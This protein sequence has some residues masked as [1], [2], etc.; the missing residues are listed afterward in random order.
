[1]DYRIEL[2]VRDT[3]SIPKELISEL[4]DMTIND[5][6]GNIWENVS[7]L[8]KENNAIYD[9]AMLALA[10]MIT[11]EI[12]TKLNEQVAIATYSIN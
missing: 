11:S 12:L 5:I 10:N 6:Y 8:P 7:G 3:L 4:T 1:M 2:N 9:K